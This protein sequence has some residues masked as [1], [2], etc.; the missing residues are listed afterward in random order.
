MKFLDFLLNALAIGVTF[1]YGSTGEIITEK[2]GHLNL[3]IPG[4]MGVG[5]ACGCAALNALCAIGTVPPALI[6]I[7]GLLAA[8]AGGALMGLLYSF[9]AVT[10]RSNQNVTGLAMT[11]FGIGLTKFVFN[12][13]QQTSVAGVKYLTAIKYYRFP[14]SGSTTSLQYLGVMVFLGIAIA[15]VSS[16]ILTRT[17]VGLHL[18]AVGESPA[19]ADAAGINV[20]RYKYVATIIGSAIAALGGLFYIMDYQGSQEAYLSVE[21]MGWLSVALVIFSLWRPY[22][23]IFGSFVF[24]AL[25]ILGSYLPSFGLNIDVAMSNLAKTLPYVVT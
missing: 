19:T 25:Y 11:I 18:R 12:R 3:G 20:T 13:I 14:F 4:I 1:L 16:V 6:V 9:L 15:V 10:L 5:A 2:A 17:R 23:S 24:G 8:L 22:I 21:A 7:L